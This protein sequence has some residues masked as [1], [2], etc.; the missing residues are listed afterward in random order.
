MH[1]NS[2]GRHTLYSE[3]TQGTVRISNRILT[4]ENSTTNIGYNKTTILV[5][6]LSAAD[7]KCI[8]AKC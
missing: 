5:L 7:K 2:K 1:V 4:K 6:A 8:N 3:L